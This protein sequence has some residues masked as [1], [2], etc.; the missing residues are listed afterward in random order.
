MA[1]LS[2]KSRLLEVEPL[3]T[4]YHRIISN[5][6][7]IWSEGD[8]GGSV[9]EE[10]GGEE[11]PDVYISLV[12]RNRNWNG[13]LPLA[14][15]KLFANDPIGVNN[16]WKELDALLATW[17]TQHKDG[18]PVTRDQRWEHF[19]NISDLEGDELEICLDV[20][21]SKRDDRQKQRI[22][23]ELMV[24][25]KHLSGHCNSI[26]LNHQ[27]VEREVLDEQ[28]RRNWNKPEQIA[29]RQVLAQMER[30]REERSLRS[31]QQNAKAEKKR[32]IKQQLQEKLKLQE[33]SKRHALRV[34]NIF[35]EKD[36]EKTGQKRKC[37]DELHG[38]RK[39]RKGDDKKV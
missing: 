32:K 4:R 1:P 10:V 22:F 9:I 15:T 29:Y 7:I 20:L 13:V 3:G 35:E 2:P 30:D 11:S 39:A 23:E 6:R 31:R 24:N 34:T 17:A 27:E 37:E 12:D 38:E 16:A 26:I 36:Q 25:Y 28:V 18:H 5:S 21:K 8:L 19:W 33:V 14:V